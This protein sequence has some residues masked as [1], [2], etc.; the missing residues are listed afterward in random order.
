MKS[1]SLLQTAYRA[2]ISDSSK[3]RFSVS[4]FKKLGALFS[5]TVKEETKQRTVSLPDIYLEEEDSEFW[6]TSP[7]PI[8]QNIDC[9]SLN[10]YQISGS[11]SESD[12]EYDYCDHSGTVGENHRLASQSEA[13][14]RTPDGQENIYA[15]PNKLKEEKS[16]DLA[17]NLSEH[18]YTELI[19]PEKDTSNNLSVWYNTSCLKLPQDTGKQVENK[20][21]P[22]YHSKPAD[23]ILPVFSNSRNS[24]TFQPVLPTTDPPVESVKSNSCDQSGESFQSADTSQSALVTD[25][26]EFDRTETE[27]EEVK[28][29]TFLKTTV[30]SDDF[31][32]NNVPVSPNTPEENGEF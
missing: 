7:D 5:R 26:D 9:I 3:N 21:D 32:A 12:S 14:H 8:Y 25:K 15:D 27:E 11:E 28:S 2:P 20:E 29:N 4:S 23:L 18:Q 22:V 30:G 17:S 16:K 31:A 19:I 6:D 13:D 10:R 24:V 1:N